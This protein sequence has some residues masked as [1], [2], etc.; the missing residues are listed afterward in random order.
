MLF[1]SLQPSCCL[2]VYLI[3]ILF[4]TKQSAFRDFSLLCTMC[5]LC[6]HFQQCSRYNLLKI[7]NKEK[8][9]TSYPFQRHNKKAEPFIRN[10]CA[11]V[12]LMLLQTMK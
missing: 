4:R 2:S 11:K 6:S 8:H 7:F 3:L 10:S 9:L 5:Q 12:V 1:D